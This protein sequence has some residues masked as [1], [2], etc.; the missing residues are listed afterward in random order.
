MPNKALSKQALAAIDLLRRT[1]ATEFA[2]RFQDDD[3]PVVWIAQSGYLTDAH[4]RPVATGKPNRYEVAAALRPEWA[5][6]RLCDQLMDGGQCQH[7]N[8]PTGIT[9]D[10][11]RMP[12]E[13]MVCWYQY[14]PE[15][16]TYRRS[17]E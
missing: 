14:D 4:G 7:C 6:Y 17:C 5:I 11:E 8:R 12:M 13:A 3:E 15:L 2:I 1:G 10:F 16:N 9:H